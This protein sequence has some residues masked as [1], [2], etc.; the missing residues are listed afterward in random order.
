MYRWE[1]FGSLVRFLGAEPAA[2]AVD[3]VV[4]AFSRVWVFD[5]AAFGILDMRLEEKRGQDSFQVVRKI[6]NVLAVEKEELGSIF[7]N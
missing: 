4:A 6:D 7:K 3:L 1:S 5:F 2:C